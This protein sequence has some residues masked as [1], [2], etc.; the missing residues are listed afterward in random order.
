MADV[1]LTLLGPPIL[2]RADTGRLVPQ[3]SAKALALLTYLALESGLH[4]REELAG[5]LWGESSD[6]EARASLRQALKHLRGQIGELLRISRAS[7]G[8]EGPL[9]CE[10]CEFRRRVGPGAALRSPQRFRASSR[11]S[12]FVIL[13]DSKSG[14]PR[15]GAASCINTRRP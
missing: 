14:P 4:S 1:C 5:L 7:V 2:A 15:L 9:D 13:H 3:P 6:D 8:L 11:V 12:P 10:V